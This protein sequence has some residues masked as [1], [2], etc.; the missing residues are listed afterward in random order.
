MTEIF[1]WAANNLDESTRAY[2]N[3][4][5]ESPAWEVTLRGLEQQYNTAMASKPK[6]SEMKHQANAANPAGVETTHAYGSMFEFTKERSDPR[7][8]KDVRYTNYVN[9]RASRTQWGSIS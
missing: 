6:A 7:Y 5:L 8:G 9:D 4:G 3:S 1:T 2:I